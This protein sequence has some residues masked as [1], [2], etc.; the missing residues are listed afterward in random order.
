MLKCT[1][2]PAVRNDTLS[3][4]ELQV[5]KLLGFPVCLP[6]SQNECAAKID[7]ERSGIEFHLTD[8]IQDG[9]VSG[10]LDVSIGPNDE[11]HADNSILENDDD[12]EKESEG[13][14]E[15]KENSIFLWEN[16]CTNSKVKKLKS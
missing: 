16:P 11:T 13:K 5:M 14:K 4:N 7:P 1:L 2:N 8:C 3:V 15:K 6:A 12:E 10:D 9:Y